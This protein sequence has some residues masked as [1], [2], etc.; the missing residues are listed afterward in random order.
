[1]ERAVLQA[2]QQF[3]KVH[4]VFHAAGLPG[5]TTMHLQTRDAALNVLAP[6]VIG[7]LIL[8]SLFQ[9]AD[10][11]FM[12]LFSSVNVLF[13]FV[14]TADYTAANFFLDSY[15]T[16]R[17]AEGKTVLSIDWDAWRDVGMAAAAATAA[18]AAVADMSG[19]GASLIEMM[20]R[21][22]IEPAEGVEALRRVLDVSVPRVAILKRSLSELTA[23][24]GTIDSIIDTYTNLADSASSE[25]LSRHS[26]PDLTQD[27]VEPQNDRELFI[28][29]LWQEL[30]GLDRIG[31]DDD[32]FDLGGHSLI[33]TGLLTRIQ[34]EYQ[35]KLPLR[36]IFEAPTVRQLA[37]RLSTLSWAT[38]S[39]PVPTDGESR[40]EFEI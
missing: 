34:K 31:I 8:D 20:V 35:V 10:L 4:G 33:A 11:D 9:K 21:N 5:T 22:T 6:K 28:A 26:R 25:T 29:S 38:R 17:H 37:E 30:L 15:A 1:M 12:V 14:G 18:T 19:R 39:V 32:F 23:I 24:S 16:A 27:F 3:G 40:E 13:G 7:T 36:A 2:R